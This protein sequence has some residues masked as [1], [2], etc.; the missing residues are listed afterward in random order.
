MKK[1]IILILVPLFSFILAKTQDCK[2]YLPYEAGTKTE[3]VNYNKKDKA[4][5]ILKQE[6]TKVEHKDGV[7][8]FGVKQISSDE[9]GNDPMEN[10]LEFTCKDGIFY[11]DMN[12][13]MDQKRMEAYGE[14]EMEVSMTE[15]EIPSNPE[16]G[17]ELKDA[18]LEIKFISDAPVGMS[19]IMDVTNRKV[20][21]FE[22][23]TTLR[24]APLIA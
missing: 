19:M 16:A 12:T 15:M 23:I 24:Q 20:E 11:I 1:H 18:T 5:G 8:Y 9:K 6:I 4:T 17:Q 2:A 10:E 13:V 22:K 7:S 3:T 14:M 21:A